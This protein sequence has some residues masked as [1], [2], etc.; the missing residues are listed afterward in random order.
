[1]DGR[2]DDF[3]LGER[4]KAVEWVAEV[5]ADARAITDE[6]VLA[7]AKG[8]WDAHATVKWDL[9]FRAKPATLQF[10]LRS[11]RAGLEAAL[12]LAGGSASAGS[13]PTTPDAGS[14]EPA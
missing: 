6:M 11:A 8:S 1:M 13:P 9:F 10:Y 7:C 2:A 12:S 14:A 5:Q 4:A 3:A